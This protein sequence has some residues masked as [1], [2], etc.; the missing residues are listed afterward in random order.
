[1]ARENPRY[2]GTYQITADIKLTIGHEGDHLFAELSGSGG[3]KF[4]IFPESETRFFSDN[5]PVELLFSHQKNGRMTK[6]VV[7]EQ[8]SAQRVQ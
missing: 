7:N 3:G 6:V 4:G 2:D 1:M 5:P 8:Y